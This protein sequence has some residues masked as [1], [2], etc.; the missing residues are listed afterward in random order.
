MVRK[1]RRRRGEGRGS[2]CHHHHHHQV[3]G[4]ILATLSTLCNLM[5]TASLANVHPP[6]QS[7]IFAG[8][9]VAKSAW[10][11]RA[12]FHFMDLGCGLLGGQE[13]QVGEEGCW[14]G[15]VGNEHTIEMRG[16]TGFG[17]YRRSGGSI[18]SI[19]FTRGNLEHCPQH[20]ETVHTKEGMTSCWRRQWGR[21][22]KQK[23]DGASLIRII[24]LN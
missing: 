2:C 15:L 24:I 22:R 17:F 9:S 1:R 19:W 4:A 10:H 14:Q 11:S 6:F 21:G 20:S 13:A 12:L 16:W 8:M 7:L 5:L 3:P 18:F 23:Y